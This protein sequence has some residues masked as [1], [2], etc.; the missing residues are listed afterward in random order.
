MNQPRRLAQTL[1]FAACMLAC[2]APL[3]QTSAQAASWGWNSETVTGSG[4]IVRQQRALGH[5]TGVSNALAAKVEVRIGDTE[6]LTIETDDNVLPLVETVIEN[7][8]LKIQT[9]KNVNL[10][11]KTMKI[12]IQA[13]SVDRLS[14]GGSG[15]IDTDPLRARKLQLDLGGSGTINVKGVEADAVSANLGGSGDIKLAGGSA[16][17]V[18]ISIGGSGTV[19][20]GNVRSDSVSVNVAGSGDAT[21]WARDALS[22]NVVGSGDVNYYGD[23]RVSTTVLGSGGTH[24]LGATPDQASR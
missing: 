19:K 17:T 20:M 22:L 7:G 18:S 21:V 5:F 24:R 11:T 16:K 13:K 8:T 2:A 9:K 14:L 10:R 4:N 12:V 1:M 6:G 15:S 23:P 3:T